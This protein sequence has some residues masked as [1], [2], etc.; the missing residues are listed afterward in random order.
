MSSAATWIVLAI[1]AGIVEMVS[2]LFGFVFVTGAALVAALAATV[3]C[4]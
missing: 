3:D 2:P 1:F 4:R